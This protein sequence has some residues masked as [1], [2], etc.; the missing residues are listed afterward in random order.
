MFMANLN[1]QCTLLQATHL[2]TMLQT[3]YS[4]CSIFNAFHKTL[5]VTI[6]SKGTVN[7]LA[8]CKDVCPLGQILYDLFFSICKE[9]ARNSASL[10]GKNIKKEEKLLQSM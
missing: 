6:F 7:G 1:V 5:K 10:F 4:F 8:V 3:K 9:N 2:D